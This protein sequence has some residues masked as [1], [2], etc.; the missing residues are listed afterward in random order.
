MGE[1]QGQSMI[2]FDN[3]SWQTDTTEDDVL[4]E[5]RQ[6]QRRCFGMVVQQF[7]QPVPF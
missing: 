1:L 5:E 6:V 4:F 7:K 3:P 2:L